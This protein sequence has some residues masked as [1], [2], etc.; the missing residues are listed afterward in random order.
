MKLSAMQ[1]DTSAIESGE[2]VGDIPEFDDLRVRVRGIEN[3]AARHL[4][5]TLI[6]AVPRARRRSGNL[7][8]EDTDRITSALLLETVLID[9]DGIEDETGKAI[10]YDKGL[11]RDL[12]TK[13]ENRKFRDAVLYAA[14][15][16]GEQQAED[17]AQ[18]A[19]N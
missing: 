1:V 8:V 18:D 10:P 5:A 13:P 11:A 3:E 15:L 2:W 19:K 9:W 14:S 4:R 16:V 7:S 6:N 17:E 12:L